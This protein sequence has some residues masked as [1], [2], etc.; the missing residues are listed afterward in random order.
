MFHVY[1]ITNHI[2]DED[3]DTIIMEQHTNMV[4]TNHVMKEE[5][6]NQTWGITIPS[7]RETHA[8]P[9]KLAEHMFSI[10][11]QPNFRYMRI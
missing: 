4:P 8:L 1:S 10:I 9:S 6:N 11:E 3:R 2:G 5:T 7:M